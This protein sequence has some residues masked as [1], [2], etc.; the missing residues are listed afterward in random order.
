MFEEPLDAFDCFLPLE[1]LV[2]NVW[3]EV[4]EFLLIIEAITT[5]WKKNNNNNNKKKKK[6]KKDKNK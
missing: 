2:S 5:K 6:R 4:I 3:V 1:E